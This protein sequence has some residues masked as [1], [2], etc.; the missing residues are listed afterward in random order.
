[1]AVRQTGYDGGLVW[2]ES[3]HWKLSQKGAHLD[4]TTAELTF[5]KYELL[6]RLAVGGMAE[7]FLARSAAMGGVLRACVIKR[8]LPELSHDPHFVSMFIDEAR[9]TLG[10]EHPNIVRLFEFGQV[11]DRYFMAMELVD[12]MDVADLLR[13]HKRAGRRLDFR[14][15][16]Y[17]A[18]CVARALDHAHGRVDKRGL[19]LGIVHRDVSPHNVFL[20]WRGEVK[21]GDF[22]IAAARNK[23]TLT[24][25]GSVKGKF[26]YMAPEQASGEIVCHRADLWALGVVLHEMLT[27]TR[28]F[29]ADSPVTTLGKV[30]HERI[31]SP[32]EKCPD[33]PTELDELVRRA[34]ARSRGERLQSASQFAH[35]LEGYLGSTGGY[36]ARD[37][38]AY[39][40]SGAEQGQFDEATHEIRPATE[41]HTQQSPMVLQKLRAK[42]TQE[43][44]VQ[45]AEEF[46]REP[47]LWT[48]VRMGRWHLAAD[49]QNSALACFRIAASVFAH[50]GM[51]IQAVC[52]YDPVKS[53]AQAQVVDDE[54]QLLA[55]LQRAPRQRLLSVLRKFDHNDYVSLLLSVEPELRTDED[56]RTVVRH[57]APLLGRL[58]PAEFAAF[59]RACR[60]RSMDAG[61]VIVREGERGSALFGV[62]RGRLT[63]YC[64]PS[65]HDTSSPFPGQEIPGASTILRQAQKG[66]EADAREARVYL[67]ALGDGDIFGEFSFLTGRQRTAT[68]ETITTTEIL[69]FERETGDKLFALHPTFKEPLLEF[70][71]ER[72]AE[73]MM[74]KN[75]VFALLPPEGRRQLLQ[76]SRLL[77]FQ[78]AEFIV[79]EGEL[80]EELYV[81]KNGEVEV[82]RDEDG[83]PVFLNKLR[84]GE[85]FGEISA[86]QKTPRLASV[87]AM[88]DVEV[89]A[90]RR[91]DLDQLL[92]AEQEVRQLLEAAMTW[93]TADTAARL[94]ETRQLL[95]ST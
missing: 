27:C 50:R 67:S 81:I 66:R 17:I 93:R 77:S 68:V 53:L 76:R 55:T 75:P 5:G 74:A 59:A 31:P 62:G 8:M 32:R 38:A 14:A 46:V 70:Y 85:F 47:D 90:I 6:E 89:L 52:A 92:N 48:L 87:R 95:W 91:S 10:L 34:L 24:N 11:R 28:L 35:V 36:Q 37:L 9:I 84:E 3:R 13:D 40:A 23:A 44:L 79:R 60:V 82:S 26:S 18:L 16:A 22:G 54:L 69:E 20:S 33:V 42:A 94:E 73:L 4:M 19:P 2:L 80:G 72:V 43:G 57:P 45:L 56:E 39:L 83:I 1:M 15:A 65:G 30:L 51:L 12:G 86:L 78:D 29:A 58:P 21:L 25:V 49:E 64:T 41:D 61:E 71:K 7:I 88:G 63:V